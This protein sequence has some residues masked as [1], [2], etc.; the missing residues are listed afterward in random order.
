MIL[1]LLIAIL[2]LYIVSCLVP[3]RFKDGKYWKL[4]FGTLSETV[5]NHYCKAT[6]TRAVIIAAR[7]MSGAYALTAFGWPLIRIS[8]SSEHTELSLQWDSLGLIPLLSYLV[9]ITIMVCLY[10]WTQRY[11]DKAIKYAHD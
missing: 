2:G 1:T 9:L 11:D 8:Y 10:L 6:P 3:C 7:G 5:V 4:K